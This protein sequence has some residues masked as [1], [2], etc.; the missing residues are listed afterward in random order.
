MKKVLVTG[1]YGFIG[2]HTVV[3][4]YDAGYE[5]IVVDNLSS[6]SKHVGDRI[7]EITGATHKFY[8]GELS[9][10]NFMR[11]V[12]EEN[13]DIH[14]VIHFA[15]FK[16]VTESMEKPT[17]YFDNN[18]ANLIFLLDLC[19]QFNANMVFSSSC[20]VYGTSTNIP[21]KET[22]PTNTQ[23]SPYGTSKAI[24]ER[25]IEV[26][27]NNTAL[28]SVSLRYF[29]PV[30]AHESGLIGEV[31]T[32][33]AANLLPMIVAAATG[34]R[35][36]LNIFGTDY[37]TKDGSCVR[38]FIHVSDVADA[39]VAALERM[40]QN[41]N[42]YDVFNI[43]RGEGTTV[44]E[45]IEKFEQI[46]DVTVPKQLCGRRSGDIVISWADPTK[47]HKELNWKAK[48]TLSDIV[49]SAWQF[50]KNSYSGY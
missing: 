14:S 25:L 31:Y 7:N 40:N 32:T 18:V 49:R 35:A 34:R 2:S 46:N 12:F 26:T 6:S 19:V 43:G 20:T 29:N 13:I 33:S 4:L 1:G 47:S 44:L 41:S 9:D 17:A 8:F 45:L 16:S 38:D 23:E 24:A 50:S 11:S 5:C 15:A 36:D 30:G 21:L 10:R 39:H 48:R 37:D 27:A 28:Q 42:S 3:A 22:H